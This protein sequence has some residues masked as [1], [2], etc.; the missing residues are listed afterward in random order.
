M[1]R[2]A[3][4]AELDINTGTTGAADVPEPPPA[5][6]PASPET[7]GMRLTDMM[8]LPEPQR[9]HALEAAVEAGEVFS[10]KAKGRKEVRV[11]YGEHILKVPP[12]PKPF[13]AAHAIHLLWTVPNLV[14]EVEEED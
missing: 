11:R 12:K 2:G 3:G 6:A 4:S 9:T 13:I 10:L 1:R 7:K 8:A 5:A 14:E